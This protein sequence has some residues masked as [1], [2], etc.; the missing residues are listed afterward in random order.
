M[1]GRSFGFLLAILGCATPAPEVVA[2]AVRLYNAA[3]PPGSPLRVVCFGAL[4][5][6]LLA[7]RMWLSRRASE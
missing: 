2:Y 3:A 5:T 4:A 6:V 7:R 1:A